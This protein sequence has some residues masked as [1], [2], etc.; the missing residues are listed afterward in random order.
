MGAHGLALAMAMFVSFWRQTTV[1]AQ[2][3]GFIVTGL[4]IGMA[5]YSAELTRGA[6]GFL[7]QRPSE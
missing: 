4:T 2:L 6:L 5:P 3:A 1:L 7:L